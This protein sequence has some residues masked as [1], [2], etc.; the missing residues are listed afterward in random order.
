MKT[1]HFGIDIAARKAQ[2][3][4]DGTNAITTT[5]VP[6]V[7]RAIARLLSLPVHT[8]SPSSPSLPSLSDYRNKFVYINSFS[9]SQNDMLAAV[10]RATNTKP[11]DWTVTHLTTDQVIQ[12]GRDRIANGDWTGMISVLYGCTFKRGLGDQFHG[13]EVANQKLGLEGEDL[14]EVVRRVVKEVEAK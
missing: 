6:Q 4:D 13:R 2:I 11:A 9:V 8:S 14:D 7:G 5:T 3:Y 1:G 12:D 10:Q